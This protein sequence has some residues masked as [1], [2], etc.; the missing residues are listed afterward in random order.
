MLNNFGKFLIVS[1]IALIELIG[2]STLVLAQSTAV[3]MRL[4][5][6]EGIY[7]MTVPDRDTTRAAYGGKLRLYDVHIA[8]MFEVTYYDCNNQGSS[9]TW[10]YYA[11]N[12]QVNMGE[13]FISCDLANRMVNRYGLGQPESTVIEY[14][15]EEAGPPIPRTRSIEILD[16]TGSKV[17]SWIDFVQNFKPVR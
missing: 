8:K 17:D 7:T 16:I 10:L 3:P 4:Q 11:G 1:I 6:G 12:G 13:F 2:N 5:H 9:R 14:S 15:Q